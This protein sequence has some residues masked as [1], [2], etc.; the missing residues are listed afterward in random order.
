MA[1]VSAVRECRRRNVL[2]M[3]VAV[4]CR[5]VRAGCNVGVNVIGV[6]FRWLL[7]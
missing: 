3:M 5:L 4:V 2:F 1:F 6:V 7:V